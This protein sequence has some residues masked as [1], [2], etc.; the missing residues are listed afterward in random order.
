MDAKIVLL[1]GDGIGP[2]V[3]AEAEKV[4]KVIAERNGHAFELSSH[5]MGGNAIDDF[6]D[7]LP[8]ETLAA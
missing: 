2:E 7:P 1:P 3:T 6:G 4:L 5:P 8:D